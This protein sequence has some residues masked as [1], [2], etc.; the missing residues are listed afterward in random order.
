MTDSLSIRRDRV[1]T[2]RYD[3]YSS[4]GELYESNRSDSAG[5][6]LLYGHGG[7]LAGLEKALLGKAAGDE[8]DLELSPELAFGHRD[9][10]LQQRISKKH[11]TNP[12]RLAVG[13]IAALRTREGTRQVTVVKVGAKMVDVDLNHPRAGE[14]LRVVATVESVREATPQE[15]AHGHAHGA[16]GHNH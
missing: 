16:G 8:L 10:S 12:K 6:A 14:T 15:L 9:D 11:F 5:Q 7:L 4:T 3:L 1:V 2:I 13:Q